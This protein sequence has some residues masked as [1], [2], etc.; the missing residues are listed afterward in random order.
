MK[1]AVL[2]AFEPDEIPDNQRI[3]VVRSDHPDLALAP[4]FEE[5]SEADGF[6]DMHRLGHYPF[7]LPQM[8]EDKLIRFH[9]DVTDA[10][11][12]TSSQCR[13]H[14]DD[15]LLVFGSHLD[16]GTVKKRLE[17]TRGIVGNF[18]KAQFMALLQQASEEEALDRDFSTSPHGSNGPIM[19]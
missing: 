8:A 1:V 17:R 14:S 18:S 6:D 4:D 7:Q 15:V 13:F 19:H 10:M 12:N 11:K 16:T 9:G 3:L 2:K 5:A